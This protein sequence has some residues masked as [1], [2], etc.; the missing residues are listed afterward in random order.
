MFVVNE[1]GGLNWKNVQLICN[2]TRST[3]TIS[4]EVES[5]TKLVVGE[6]TSQER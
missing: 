1:E 2:E 3:S 5:I 4:S 6:S